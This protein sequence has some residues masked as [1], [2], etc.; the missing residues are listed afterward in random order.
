M[1][2]GGRCDAELWLKMTHPFRNTITDEIQRTP[3][4]A[5]PRHFLWVTQCFELLQN[6]TASLGVNRGRDEEKAKVGTKQCQ[7]EPDE[8]HLSQDRSGTGN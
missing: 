3:I 6:Q 5:A 8:S 2:E 4:L 1:G 7:I